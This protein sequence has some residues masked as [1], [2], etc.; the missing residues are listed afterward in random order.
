MERECAMLVR[1]VARGIQAVHA[2]GLAHCDLKP[3]NILIAGDGTP[4]VSDFGI[5]IRTG[6]E[7]DR[8]HGAKVPRRPLAGVA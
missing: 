2:F 3:D 5:A 4:R 8:E 7:G 1:D 6:G